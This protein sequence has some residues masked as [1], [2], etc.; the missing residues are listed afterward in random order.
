MKWVI[1]QKTPKLHFEV[2]SVPK[3]ARLASFL[4]AVNL[5]LRGLEVLSR[6]LVFDLP[7]MSAFELVYAKSPGVDYSTG[8][9]F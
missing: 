4:L 7:S 6:D 5:L 3:I 1:Y 2:D 9:R 8:L